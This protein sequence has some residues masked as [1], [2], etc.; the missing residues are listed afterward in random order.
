MCFLIAT[1]FW[2]DGDKIIC[3]DWLIF[4][5][6]EQHG[7]SQNESYRESPRQ[8]LF[9]MIFDTHAHYDDKAFDE[10]RERMLE[11]LPAGGIGTVVDV[12]STLESISIVEEI[13]DTHEHVY[14]ALGI[15]PSECAPLTNELLQ[16]IEERIRKDPKVVAVGEIGLDYH[17]P[18]PEPSLQQHWLREQLSMARR[19]GKPVIIH[20]RDAA[21]DT[22]D[23][24]KEQ[25]IEQIGGV[26]HCYS[27]SA[28]MAREFVKL[29]MYLGI[30]GVVTFKNARKVC[31]VVRE[32]PLEH[33]VLETDCPYMAPTP[34]RGQRNSSLY[35]P[36]V[37]AKIAEIKAITTEAVI[38]RTT[39]NAR[40]LY[41]LD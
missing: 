6:I 5:N 26:M 17:W 28:E 20:S 30:G 33:L 38:R 3:R 37:A 14:A 11:S 24:L 4:M 27:Y 12:A 18:E 9:E 1:A 36:L 8:N 21:Q 16:Q 7:E 19:T 32:I 35:L 25:H 41:R 31:E 2:A 22:F 39:E 13:A 40:K 10:D 15:H 23:I 34:H 29:G